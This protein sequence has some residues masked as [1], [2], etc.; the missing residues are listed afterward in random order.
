M[1]RKL[2]WSPGESALA[3]IDPELAAWIRLKPVVEAML[4]LMP[5]DRIDALRVA[6]RIDCLTRGY[7]AEYPYADYH[8]WN[9]TKK[10]QVTTAA[11]RA[12]AKHQPYAARD[13]M[14]GGEAKGMRWAFPDRTLLDALERARRP[15]ESLSEAIVRLAGEKRPPEAESEIAS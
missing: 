2:K 12:L 6:F 9:R 14:S 10:V 8:D 1:K 5:E 7:D 15:D 11:W 13:L 4:A 3:W